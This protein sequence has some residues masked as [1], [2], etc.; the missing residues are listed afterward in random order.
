VFHRDLAARIHEKISNSEKKNAL[1]RNGQKIWA[2]S[3]GKKT[4][5]RPMSGKWVCAKTLRTT[6]TAEWL[7]KTTVRRH[8]WLLEWLKIKPITRANVGQD[9]ERRGSP[10]CCAWHKMSVL[11]WEQPAVF[12]VTTKIWK[13]QM[14][15]SLWYIHTIEIL[16]SDDKKWATEPQKDTEEP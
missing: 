8:H 9:K 1:V 2:N 14:Y 7:I 15:H 4:Y 3:L 6:A 10:H 16:I 12:F 13:P 11:S 5:I